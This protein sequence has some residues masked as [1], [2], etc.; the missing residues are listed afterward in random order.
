MLNEGNKSLRTKSFHLDAK[1]RRKKE[2]NEEEKSE[3]EREGI[4]KYLKIF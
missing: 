1:E 3:R 2:V 4:K